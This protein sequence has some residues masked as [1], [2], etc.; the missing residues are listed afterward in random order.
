VWAVSWAVLEED[1]WREKKSNRGDD[2]IG[3]GASK[4]PYQELGIA[5]RS[6]SLNA[7]GGMAMLG[8]RGGEGGETRKDSQGLTVNT[9]ETITA[10]R[11]RN[12][13]PS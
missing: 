3:R 13:E 9:R 1:F 7:G 12:R 2:D 5:Q 8:E 4:H 6:A 11:Y 10:A